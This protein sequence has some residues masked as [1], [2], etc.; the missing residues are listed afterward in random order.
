MKNLEEKELIISSGNLEKLHEIDKKL[1]EAF[2]KLHF[3]W[4]EKKIYKMKNIQTFEEFLSE[5]ILEDKIQ[6]GKGDNTAEDSVDYEELQV[7]IAV[8]KEHTSDTEL[9]KEIALDHLTENPKYYSEL[10]FKG[11]VDEKE[12][13]E[14]AKKFNW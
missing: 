5:S 2:Q 12:A 6:G 7:G 4:K 13:L 3:F 11:I 1:L 14:L 9:A 10:I 8:E